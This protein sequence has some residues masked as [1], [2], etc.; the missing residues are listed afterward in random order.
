VTGSQ[1]DLAQVAAQ[2]WRDLG[3]GDRKV[4]AREIWERIPARHR[5]DALLVALEEYCRRFNAQRRPTGFKPVAGVRRPGRSAKV[6]AIRESWPALRATIYT[7]GGQKPFGEC[8][9]ADLIFHAGLLERQ[10]ATFSRKAAYERELAAAL[11]IHR[12]QQVGQLPAGVL[13]EYVTARS[14]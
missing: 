4:L 2:A 11:D 13:A 10:A 1:F 7:P 12:V 9:S 8:T 3:G 14:G 5:G 6:T